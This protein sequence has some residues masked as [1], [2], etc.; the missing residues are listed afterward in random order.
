M[1]KLTVALAVVAVGL[2]VVGLAMS[3]RNVVK[4]EE[5]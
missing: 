3:V 2:S 1:E 4:K 5:E